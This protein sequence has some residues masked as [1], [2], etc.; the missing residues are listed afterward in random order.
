MTLIKTE[1]KKYIYC[2]NNQFMK[3]AVALSTVIRIRRQYKGQI[4]NIDTIP[5]PIELL[6]SCT[7][8]I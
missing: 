3:A 1:F 5:K 8:I 7:A 4:R 6:C 2:I